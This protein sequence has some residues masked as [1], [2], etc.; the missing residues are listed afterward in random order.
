MNSGVFFGNRLTFATNDICLAWHRRLFRL[1]S[2]PGKKEEIFAYCFRAY[3]SESTD[4]G[5]T[6]HTTLCTAN[7]MHVPDPGIEGAKSNGFV[8]RQYPSPAPSVHFTSYKEL[9]EF[10]IRRMGFDMG[11]PWK[12]SNVNADFSMC[13]TYPPYLLIPGSINDDLLRRVAGYRSY[14]RVPNVVWR[15]SGNGAVIA[16]CSQP[17]VTKIL[18]N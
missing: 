15:H 6:L 18:S 16:R 12:I 1:T 8:P 10:E 3:C 13:S 5:K 14:G 17:Q 9:L 4:E 11:G 2:L 7:H